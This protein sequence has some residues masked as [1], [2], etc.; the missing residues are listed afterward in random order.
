MRQLSKLS[1]FWRGYESNHAAVLG[2]LIVLAFF[3]VA[4]MAPYL[5]PY[6]PWTSNVVPLLVPP[7]LKYPMGTDSV[8]RDMYSSMIFGTRISLLVGIIAAAFSTVIGIL[9]GAISGYIGGRAD[10][11]LMRAT[12]TIQAVPPFFLIIL[13]VYLLKPTV[14]NIIL[15]IGLLS[16]P[17]TARLVRAEFLTLKERE[18]VEAARAIGIG[19]MGLIF[20]EILPNALSPAIVNGSLDVGRAI[21]IQAGLSFLGLGD[22]NNPDWGLMLN[23]AQQFL[24]TAWWIAAFPGLFI[25]LLVLSVNLIGDGLEDALNIRIK[26]TLIN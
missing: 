25:S 10:L 6:P 24:T 2:L 8:G 16:W 11:L 12:E 13:I 18:F 15:V 21:L 4:A 9:V 17:I 1:R 7:N 19:R 23:S 14:W 3:I 26:R 5:A 20:K 22:I